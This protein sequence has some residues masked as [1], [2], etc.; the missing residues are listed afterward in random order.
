MVWKGER[1]KGKLILKLDNFMEK[2]ILPLPDKICPR[3]GKQMKEITIH[4]GSSNKRERVMICDP[5]SLKDMLSDIGSPHEPEIKLDLF[6]QI[7][8]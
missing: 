7:K 5:C 4:T 1:I 6:S 8:Q 2:E 3:C